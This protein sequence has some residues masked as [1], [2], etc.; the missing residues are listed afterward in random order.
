[1]ILL[2]DF[3]NKFAEHDSLLLLALTL[4]LDANSPLLLVDS[5]DSHTENIEYLPIFY[6]PTIKYMLTAMPHGSKNSKLSKI[7][8]K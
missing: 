4:T 2:K 3:P 5:S 6:T 7:Q 1:M 8:L